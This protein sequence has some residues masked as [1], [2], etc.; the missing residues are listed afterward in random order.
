MGT[1][2]YGEV[3]EAINLKTGKPCAIKFVSEK[4]LGSLP[5][6][7]LAMEIRH[8]N[9]LSLNQTGTDFLKY[10]DGRQEK[11][12]FLEMDVADGGE[13]F[14]WIAHGGRFDEDLGRYYFSEAMRGI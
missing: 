12:H 1:G 10:A 7:L 2:G 5:D 8:R 4:G 3:R 11:K 14:D 6:E 9:V 13:L